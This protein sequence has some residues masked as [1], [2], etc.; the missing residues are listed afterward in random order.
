MPERNDRRFSVLMN[1]LA[2]SVAQAQD[3]DIV[4]EAQGESAEEIRTTLLAA[5]T[6]HKRAKLAKA[7]REYDEQTAKYLKRAFP[8]PDA[9]A[10]RRDLL[11]RTLK[12][13]AEVEQMIMAQF[14]DFDQMTDEDVES[15]LHQ[16][17]E[18]GLLADHTENKE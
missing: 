8:L 15:L 11:R 16:L 4:E 18:L 9:P 14:R 17:G 7:R 12:Q 3:E 5:V 1:A 2:D 13:R 10:A 6:R